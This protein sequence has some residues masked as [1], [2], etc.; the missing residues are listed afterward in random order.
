MQL[1]AKIRLEVSETDSATLEFMQAKCRGLYNWWIMKLRNG[2]KWSF[3][4]CKKTLAES[5]VH[6]PELDDVYG[7]L[8][9]EVYYRLDAAMGRSF[10]GIK[11]ER[12]LVS[13]ES[14]RD[15]PSSR[16]AILRCTSR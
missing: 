9:A 3:K 8:L 1:C 14:D 6:D 4:R 15:T 11:Q 2:E 10:A 13:L 16:S 12:P 7:K 5:R